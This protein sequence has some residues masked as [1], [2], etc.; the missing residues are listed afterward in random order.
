MFVIYHDPGCV[1]SVLCLA[2]LRSIKKNHKKIEYI[3]EPLTRDIIKNLLKKLQ[4]SAVDLIRKDHVEWL[5]FYKKIPLT[6]DEIIYLM[7]EKQGFITLPIIV[8]DNQVV[9]GTPPKKLA[10][11]MN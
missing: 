4:I 5:N 7:L 1:Y 3:K 6:E 8:N 10:H 2:V 9:V 11:F